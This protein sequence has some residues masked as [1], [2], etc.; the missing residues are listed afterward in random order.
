MARRGE[1]FPV[2]DQA[3]QKERDTTRRRILE[4]ELTAEMA[5]MAQTKAELVAAEK[6]HKSTDEISNLKEAVHRHE[7][8][9]QSLNNELA[10]TGE[11]KKIAATSARRVPDAKAAVP[12]ILEKYDGYQKFG[13]QESDSYDGYAANDPK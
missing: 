12:K 2:V 9:I 5:R 10:R 13:D 8:N 1:P 6:I 11:Q 3:T 4:D 7:V